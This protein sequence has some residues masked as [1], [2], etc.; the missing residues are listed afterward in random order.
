MPRFLAFA[1]LIL[2]AGAS[3]PGQTFD[4][5]AIRVT[6]QSSVGRG[7]IATQPGRVIAQEATVKEIIA[8]AYG[9][10]QD[11]VLGGPAWVGSTRY[12]I[13]ATTTGEA[14][15]A[16]AQRMLQA[17]L[18]DRFALTFHREQRNLPVYALTLLRRDGSFGKKL[19]RAGQACAPITLPD[20]DASGLAPPPP[21]P[22]P[23]PPGGNPMRPLLERESGLRCPTMFYPGGVSARSILFDEFVYRLSRLAQ[24]PILDRTGLTGEF[25]IDLSYQ[26]EMSSAGPA[27]PAGPGGPA[28]VT[29]GPGPG[30]AP[31]GAVPAGAV[32]VGGP[33][34][35]SLFSAVQDQLGLK[36]DSTRGPVDVL[37]IDTAKPPSEN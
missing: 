22:P 29:A 20:F 16:R 12:A 31:A 27:G 15:R 23:P 24:R 26:F 10:P 35:P 11:Q 19:R 8:V 30:A 34:L 2:A 25:D 1:V 18:G 4:A 36:L 9:L 17:M 6:P 3:L 7:L 33:S 5:V 14:D 13:T 32:T 28:G 37:V 21:P